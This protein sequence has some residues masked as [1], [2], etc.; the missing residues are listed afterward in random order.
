M[1]WFFEW[2]AFF[3]KYSLSDFLLLRMFSLNGALTSESA[4]HWCADDESRA[5]RLVQAFLVPFAS[6]SLVR[7]LFLVPQRD[8]TSTRPTGKQRRLQMMLDISE[9]A[10]AFT[11]YAQSLADRS[12]ALPG[13]KIKDIRADALRFGESASWKVGGGLRS[14]FH[15]FVNG[16]EPCVKIC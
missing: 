13:T 12:F 5:G 8:I 15:V 16:D 7:I 3:E 14:D 11:L 4:W 6:F 2:I 9:D 1:N 10:H